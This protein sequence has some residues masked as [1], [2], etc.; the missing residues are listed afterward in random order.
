MNSS[1]WKELYNACD[2]LM[3]S[4]TEKLK[5]LDNRLDYTELQICV[6]LKMNFIL[7]EIRIL[8]GISKSVLSHKRQRMNAK[9]FNEDGS[10]RDFDKKIITFT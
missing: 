9:L 3:P 6:L 1:E 2:T 8:L 4:F 10:A 7:S 5:G